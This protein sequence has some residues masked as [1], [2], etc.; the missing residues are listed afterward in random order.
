MFHLRG[1]AYARDALPGFPM[2]DAITGALFLLGLLAVARRQS[3]DGMRFRLLLTWPAFMV[4]GGVLSTSGEGPPYPYRVLALAPWACLVAAIGGTWLW[5][6]VRARSTS[7]VRRTAAVVALLGVVAINAWV[8]FLAGP[9]DPGTRHVYG[10]APTRLGLWL[11]EHGEGRPVVI[12]PD[13][14]TS[15]PLPPGYRYAT[16]NP[17]SF[18][19]SLDDLT[20]VHLAAGLYRHH[21]ERSLDP[22]RPTGDVD[23][24][25]ALPP[26]LAGPTLLVVPPSQ[27][28]EAWRRFHVT[29]RVQLRD[30]RGRAPSGPILATV[31]FADP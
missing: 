12:L 1:G 14:L 31:L 23:L 27:E 8:L 29:R 9:R 19:R 22:L 2:L 6:L 5:D 30:L 26:T 17:T 24:L 21:P 7:S 20:A 3:D 11:A 18:F 10:T 25:P 28:P 15:P 4:L 16:A 13:A